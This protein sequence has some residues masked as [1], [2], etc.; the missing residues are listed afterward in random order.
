VPTASF[1]NRGTFLGTT[2][3]QG[4]SLTPANGK[5][6]EKSGATA[7]AAAKIGAL[8]TRTSDTVGELTMNVGHAITTGQRL[9]IF[10][11]V[12]GVKGA[13][14]GVTV[15]TVSVN[16]VP[17]SLGAGDNL[18]AD[19]SAITAQVPAEEEFLVTGNNVTVI[20]ARATRR[21][22]VV[23]ADASNAE[24]HAIEGELDGTSTTG[25]GY[26]WYSGNGVTNPLAGDAVAKVFLSNGDSAGTNNVSVAAGHD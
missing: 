1:S 21:A 2:Y 9:D 22:C 20:L 12:G 13:R 23:F 15:G 16:Q 4:T 19:E 5:L 11:D 8:T 14:R 6:T 24:L 7:L 18:P 17:F 10:W 3:T 26:Q 25:N